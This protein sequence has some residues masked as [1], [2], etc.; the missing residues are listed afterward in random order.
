MAANKGNTPQQ[1]VHEE[2]LLQQIDKLQLI[3]KLIAFRL[4]KSEEFNKKTDAALK[5]AQ[6]SKGQLKQQTNELV[7]DMESVVLSIVTSLK[8]F[9][10]EARATLYSYQSQL[11]NSQKQ[12]HEAKTTI[13]QLNEKIEHLETLL[14]ENKRLFEVNLQAIHI[15]YVNIMEHIFEKLQELIL[16]DLNLLEQKNDDIHKEYKSAF[17]L[18]GLQCTFHDI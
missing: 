11:Q 8:S 10:S 13:R 6:Q 9:Q 5:K 18:L 4:S 12:L 17:K 1:N 2:Q 7:D 15:T 14:L 3:S 16:N